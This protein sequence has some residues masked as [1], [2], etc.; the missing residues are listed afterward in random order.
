MCP[1]EQDRPYYYVS[2]SLLHRADL[3]ALAPVR[4]FDHAANTGGHQVMMLPG[5]HHEED[6]PRSPPEQDRNRS[7]A[8]SRFLEP[9]SSIFSSI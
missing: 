2:R 7:G 6:P 9:I 1:L 3:H 8:A 4:T 5:R